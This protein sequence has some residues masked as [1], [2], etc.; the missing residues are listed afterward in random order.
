MEVCANACATPA[1][2]SKATCRGKL[3]G[4]CT[5]ASA[6]QHKPQWRPNALPL[7]RPCAVDCWRGP[8]VSAHLTWCS[9]GCQTLQERRCQRGMVEQLRGKRCYDKVGVIVMVILELSLIVFNSVCVRG[10][11]R[12]MVRATIGVQRADVSGPVPTPE[13]SAIRGQHLAF[14]QRGHNRGGTRTAHA[15]TRWCEHWGSEAAAHPKL[16]TRSQT[17][18][19]S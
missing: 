5:R 17:Y 2:L 13:H 10:A 6:G 1:Q 8:T 7:H 12:R 15:H 9:G 19:R 18:L 4:G 14:G 11:S 16:T 3:V